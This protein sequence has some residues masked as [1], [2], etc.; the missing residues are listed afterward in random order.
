MGRTRLTPDDKTTMRPQILL[1][2]RPDHKV[3][4]K[5]FYL[6]AH[7]VTNAKYATFVK[8]TRH[9]IPHHWLGGEIPRGEETF[10]AYNV[11]WDD[12]S[13]YCRWAGKRLPT[14]AEWERAARG[15][16]EG[17]SYPW[18]DKAD[19]KLARYNQPQPGPAGAY[20]PN[21]FGL[22]D[23]A[24]GVSEWCSDWFDRQ[25]YQNGP[26][27]NP[28]G[29]ESGLYKMI[30]GGAWSDPASRITVFFRNWVR[31]SQRTPNI[32]FRC[33]RSAE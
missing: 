21:G 30:R 33:A 16:N 24:G 32:G 15:G 29:P 4:L 14:E 27:E 17:Q 3:R 23:M 31:P 11:D 22:Y 18:G 20:P 7:E 5:A 6:D 1:D 28:A 25:Y 9:R 26:P 8:A 19:A 2:D 10:P 13:A 12:A